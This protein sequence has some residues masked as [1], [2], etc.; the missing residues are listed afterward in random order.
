[1]ILEKKRK[2][3]VS[4]SEK[5]RV[6]RIRRYIVHRRRLLWTNEDILIQLLEWKIPPPPDTKSWSRQIVCDEYVLGLDES[7]TGK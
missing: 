2:V 5:R 6:E 4:P 7:R 3:K 1:M